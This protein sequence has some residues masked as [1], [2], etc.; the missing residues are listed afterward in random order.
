MDKLAR[1][2]DAA[3]NADDQPTSRL[4]VPGG[5][6]Y[7][8]TDAS[9]TMEASICFVP[10]PPPDALL[11]HL[12]DEHPGL[13]PGSNQDLD[14]RDVVRTIN[15]YL[16]ERTPPIQ[17]EAP[18]SGDLKLAIENLELDIENIRKGGDT[19]TAMRLGRTVDFLNQL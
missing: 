12:L 7:K 11:N 4:P 14:P 1:W 17:Y 8:V 5:W 2:Q 6:L 3:A 13:R 10:R 18:D 16:A 9:A 19:D 15:L